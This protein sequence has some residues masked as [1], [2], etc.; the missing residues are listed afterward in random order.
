MLDAF[1]RS[2]PTALSGGPDPPCCRRPLLLPSRVTKVSGWIFAAVAA[3][4][5]V[6]VLVVGG[7]TRTGGG[8]EEDGGG[9]R[10][11][12]ERDKTSENVAEFLTLASGFHAYSCLGAPSRAVFSVRPPPTPPSLIYLHSFAMPHI[13]EYCT[14]SCGDRCE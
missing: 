7:G 4:V 5:L 3:V 1:D 9:L 12:G 11:T 14:Q 13:H 10:E 2:N 8:E 6:V